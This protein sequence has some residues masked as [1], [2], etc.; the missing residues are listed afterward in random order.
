[1]IAPCCNEG[2]TLDE[3]GQLK[4]CGCDVGLVRRLALIHDLTKGRAA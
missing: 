1:V 4:T 2:L 3:Q